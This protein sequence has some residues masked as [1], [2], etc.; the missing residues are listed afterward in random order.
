MKDIEEDFNILRNRLDVIHADHKKDLE[1]EVTS[2]AEK[3][4]I[5]VKKSYQIGDLLS[6]NK[7][8][9]AKVQ[10]IEVKLQK[11]HQ[12]LDGNFFINLLVIF[13]C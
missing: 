5:C 13:I 6:Q 4:D 2:L 1:F 10:E 7:N 3:I 9:H 8:L 12:T 11:F